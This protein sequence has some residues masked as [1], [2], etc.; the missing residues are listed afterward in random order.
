MRRTLRGRV[1]SYDWFVYFL[2][3]LPRTGF[4]VTLSDFNRSLPSSTL[5]VSIF[6]AQKTLSLLRWPTLLIS[7]SLDLISQL[8]FLSFLFLLLHWKRRSVPK[9]KKPSVSSF[10][11]LFLPTKFNESKEETRLNVTQCN[12]IYI[13]NRADSEKDHFNRCGRAKRES[14]RKKRKHNWYTHSEQSKRGEKKV[15]LSDLAIW[16]LLTIQ[17]VVS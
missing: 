12:S 9:R 1:K 5:P 16:I 11:V 2:F 17:I 6:E 7:V 13:F 4:L 8:F 14:V 3:F 10:L 15:T